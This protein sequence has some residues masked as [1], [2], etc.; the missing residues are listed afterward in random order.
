MCLCAFSAQTFQWTE[1][2]LLQITYRN[3]FT[4]LVTIATATP[5]WLYS[6]V[7]WTSWTALDTRIFLPMSSNRFSA[8]VYVYACGVAN[9]GIYFL[10]CTNVSKNDAIF[11]TKP[12]LDHG[13]ARATNHKTCDQIKI[14]DQC[15]LRGS[16]RLLVAR[17]IITLFIKCWEN[18]YGISHRISGLCGTQCSH[19]VN[20]IRFEEIDGTLGAHI[21]FFLSLSIFF[22]K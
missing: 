5:I 7:K 21:S 16:N 10:H 1:T 12:Q 15:S 4:T 17:R 2:S 14:H 11:C 22:D 18:W 19:T 8:Y 20:S 3:S 9:D 13:S 6:S